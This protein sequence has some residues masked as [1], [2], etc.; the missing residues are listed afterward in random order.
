MENIILNPI[1]DLVK[2]LND[3]GLQVLEIDDEYF[4]T[5]SFEPADSRTPYH[6]V[7]G[8]HVTKLINDHLNIGLQGQK[9]D[10]FIQLVDGLPERYIQYSSSYK[11]KHMVS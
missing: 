4:T 11:F 2:I 6:I 7:R 3:R 8:K 10:G 1:Y 9:L 5:S